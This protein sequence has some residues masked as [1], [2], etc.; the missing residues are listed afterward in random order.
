MSMRD[1][2]KEELNT[3]L[4]QILPQAVL[5]F[6][7]LVIEKNVTKSVEAAVLTRSSSQPTSSYEAAA[8]LSEFE[9]TKILIDKMEKTRRKSSKD[10]E[11]SRDSRSTDKK[12][13]NT[14][15]DPSQ[16]QH[17][18]SGKSA[19]VEEP[20]HTVEDSG[21]QQDQEFITR[22]NNE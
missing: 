22:D 1:L 14:S 17:K 15:K 16:S 5:D 3:Q 9:L 18:S 12:S 4:P 2:I 7:N 10:A 8:S 20:S 11:S 21:M 6:A 13:S 19:L